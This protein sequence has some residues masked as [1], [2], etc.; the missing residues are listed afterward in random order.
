MP[1]QGIRGILILPKTFYFDGIFKI[2]HDRET[3]FFSSL[4]GYEVYPSTIL[5]NLVLSRAA[6]KK[7]N[8]KGKVLGI[9][10]DGNSVEEVTLSKVTRKKRIL[11]Y[12]QFSRYC[13][14]FL[15]PTFLCS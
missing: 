5:K 6:I 12:V 14:L 1:K 4:P 8:T 15:D 3:S 11:I 2:S 7:E 13:E 9:Y 10:I